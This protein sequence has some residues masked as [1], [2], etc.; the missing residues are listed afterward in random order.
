[1][2]VVSANAWLLTMFLA[3]AE[4]EAL[5]LVSDIS[6]AEEVLEFVGGKYGFTELILRFRLSVKTDEDADIARVVFENAH[7]ACIITN[8]I[9]A[10]ARLEPV[11]SEG[12]SA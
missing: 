12:A 3:Y 4:P 2:L 10:S 11:F 6:S 8:S 1:M 7:R 5:E 9:T